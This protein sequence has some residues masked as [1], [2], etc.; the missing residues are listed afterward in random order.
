MKVVLCITAL[1]IAAGVEAKHIAENGGNANVLSDRYDGDVMGD[2][3]LVGDP[4]QGTNCNCG[5]D[6]WCITGDI[7]SDS[8]TWSW[9]GTKIADCVALCDST[10][11]CT[12]IEYNH[13][14]NEQ[15]VDGK[16][17]CGT[18]T[19]QWT[20][21]YGFPNHFDLQL[22]W[23]YSLVTGGIQNSEWTTCLKQPT[24]TEYVIIN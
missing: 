4:L 12:G 19:G 18:Y 24:L 15:T 16:A 6:Y 10:P 21:D 14:R 5:E 17:K 2:G 11:G 20:R 1:A 9:P 3:T 8:K 23:Y 13:G 22:Q 7:Y